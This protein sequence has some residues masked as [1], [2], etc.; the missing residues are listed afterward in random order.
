MGGI[1]K[2]TVFGVDGKIRFIWRF[3][4]F[5]LI[6]V[7]AAFA[8]GGPFYAFVANHVTIRPGLSPEGIALGEA[9][10]FIAAFVPTAIFAIYER[11][12]I[13]SY[14][15]PVGRALGGHTFEGFI[16]G[17]IFAGAV[18]L[19]MIVLGGMQVIG[20]ALSGHALAMAALAW[21][22]ANILVGIAEEFYFRHYVQQTLWKSIG[23]WPA[24]TVI[25]LL[26]AAVHY[27]LKP[28]ENIWDVITLVSF[29]LLM[30]YSVVQTGTL[31]FAVGFHCAFDYMQIFVIGTPNGEQ[32]PVDHLLDVSFHGPAWI[33]GGSLGT[34]AS[35]LVYPAMLV[36]W[37]YLW[38]RY[39][40][41]PGR[42]P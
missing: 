19:A 26:F 34:E 32:T 6:S 35:F 20:F 24:A 36:L 2:R 3:V 12:R 39:R 31:W 17:V 27:F 30:S 40:K 22:G 33:T 13:D 5:V 37:L 7:G 9:V 41:S 8:V 23:F 16:V 42:V 15:L 11:R 29:S 1:L 18:A 21:L 38:T 10:N 14:G 25:A 28:G 4:L